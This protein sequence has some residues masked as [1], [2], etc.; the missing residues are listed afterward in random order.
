MPASKGT[1]DATGFDAMTAMN[2]ETL[3]EG[4]ER[5]AKSVSTIAEFQKGAMDAMMSSAGAYARGLEKASAE[6]SAFVKEAYEDSAAATKAASTAKSVQE[7]MEIQSD[8]ARAAFEKNLSFAAKLADHWTSVT[9]EATDPLTKRYG[10]LV[11]Q[12]QTY[13]P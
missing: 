11:E 13:R 5:M 1:A 8:F 4:Y 12:V 6:H 10:E 9:K 7:A 2:P 3:K